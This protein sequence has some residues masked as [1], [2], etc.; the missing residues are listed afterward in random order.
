MDT[1]LTRQGGREVKNEMHILSLS[2]KRRLEACGWQFFQC[3][4]CQERVMRRTMDGKP[5]SKICI[6]CHERHCE[7]CGPQSMRLQGHQCPD[8]CALVSKVGDQ[9]QLDLREGE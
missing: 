7:I 4:T 6:E 5:G 3:A 9:P 2:E 1:D 8:G